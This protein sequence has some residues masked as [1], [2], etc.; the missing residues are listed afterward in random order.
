MV[1]LRL[2]AQALAIFV[3]LANLLTVAHAQERVDRNNQ[4]TEIEGKITPESAVKEF[5]TDLTAKIKADAEFVYVGRADLMRA[6]EEVLLHKSLYLVG[7]RGSGK[8][9]LVEA[10]TKEL[11]TKQILELNI[12]NLMAGTELQGAYEN[13]L[14]SLLEYVEQS[15]GK[16]ILFIDEAHRIMETRGL[17]D[18]LKPAM[19]RG[20]INVIL[21]TTFDE[22]REYIESDQALVSRGQKLAVA[23]PTESEILDFLRARKEMLEK[24]YNIRIL[25]AALKQAVRLTFI[26]FPTEAPSRKAIEIINN[27]AAAQAIAKQK[28]SYE[29]QVIQQKIMR[30]NLELT[31]IEKDL[32]LNPEDLELKERVTQIENEILLLKEEAK[33]LN[34]RDEAIREAREKVASFKRQLE[35]YTQEGKY[36]DAS[37]MKITLIPE[38]E[39]SLQSLLSPP[40]L[41]NAVTVDDVNRTVARATGKNVNNI[42]RSEKE[43]I[44][45]LDSRLKQRIIEQNEAIEA[46]SKGLKIKFTEVEAVKGPKAV[47]LFP[48]PTGTGKTETGKQ[49]A[50]ELFDSSEAL[51]RWDMNEYTESFSLTKAIGSP[52][53]YVN[54]EEGGVVTEAIRRNGHQVL[55]IDE[56]EKGAPEVRNYLLNVM[57]EGKAKDGAG[58]TVDFRNTVIIIT[59]NIGSDYLTFERGRL[60]NEDLERKYN[61]A[62]GELSGL[63]QTQIDQKIISQEFIRRGFP[64]EWLNRV[65]SISPFLPISLESAK[66]IARI[67]LTDQKRHLKEHHNIE[68]TFTDSAVDALARL[69]YNPRFGARPIARAQTEN[70][71]FLLSEL[72]LHHQAARGSVIAIDFTALE[73]AEAG[74]KF[75]ATLNGSKAIERAVEFTKISLLDAAAKITRQELGKPLETSNEGIARR[76]KG[77]PRRR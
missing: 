9:A 3:L 66:K 36:E 11:S 54:T 22:Y 2:K 32:S 64:P 16:T 1:K 20:T 57:D 62:K 28:G 53:G 7:E 75:V 30:L 48:G 27:A 59:S 41:D 63:T 60:S 71:S 39:K 17:A 77:K 50:L 42:S 56:I 19:A 12:T 67:R 49:L 13:R 65:S 15:K 40:S 68:F 51:V 38:A 21:S 52:K 34:S 47:L 69:G 55:L 74:G 23:N 8:T 37:I 58:R 18:V 45:E 31:S 25:D 6:A 24:K 10:L 26:H 35:R 5:T 70:I 43:R 61:L 14:K 76:K 72:L 46:L 33:A 29:A 44:L 73:S 4:P